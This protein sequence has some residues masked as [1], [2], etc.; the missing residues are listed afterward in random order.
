MTKDR[1]ALRQRLQDLTPSQRKVFVEAM[2][3][4]G[5]HRTPAIPRYEHGVDIPQSYTQRRLW[6]LFRVGTASAMYNMPESARLD[7]HIDMASFEGAYN[8]VIAR[9]ASLRTSFADSSAGPVQRIGPVVHR[10]VEVV[11]VRLPGGRE[12][13]DAQIEPLLSELSGRIFDLSTGPLVTATLLRVEP[14]IHYF[15]INMHHA[16]S[17]GWSTGVFVRD[18]S[19]FYRSRVEGRAP[20][21]PQLQIEFVDFV[22]WQYERMTSPRLEELRAFWRTRLSGVEPLSLPFDRQPTADVREDGGFRYIHLDLPTT[23]RL[24]SLA[25]GWGATLFMVLLAAFKGLLHRYSM[26]ND[27]TV[28]VPVAGRKHPDTE[29]LIGFFANTVVIRTDV[30]GELSFEQ[31]TSRVRD[32][33]LD[34]FEREETPFEMLVEMLK[35]ARIDG[36]NPLFQVMFILQNTKRPRLSLPGIDIRLIP[37]G[38]TSVKFDMLFELG[39]VDDGITGW[40]G[41]RKDLFDENTMS[42]FASDYK[43]LLIHACASPEMPLAQLE[44]AERPADA[45]EG[46]NDDLEAGPET[47]PTPAG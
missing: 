9:H 10:E 22:R 8:D 43:A 29:D 15:V 12:H 38:S 20:V 32:A 16:I 24:K 26:Q 35:P 4:R 1:E 27:I 28:G 45:F 13:Y 30:R 21:L 25:S 19:E 42:R 46:F 23:A 40:L 5:A 6:F 41:Y 33:S 17:D 36:R 14:E 11:D 7:G 18:F 44:L 34:A 2:R 39:E 3:S 47:S 37:T 31:L